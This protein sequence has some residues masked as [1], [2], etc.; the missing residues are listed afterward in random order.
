LD[1]TLLYSTACKWAQKQFELRYSHRKQ[2]NSNSNN[3]NGDDNEN[4]NVN[5]EKKV[6]DDDD[7][8]DDDQTVSADDDANE[9][10]M[11][12][13][14]AGSGSGSGSD[15]NS[16][17]INS[18]QELMQFLVPLIDFESFSYEM[19]F[20]INKADQVLSAEKFV[21]L[22]ERKIT[23]D[24]KKVVDDNDV[25]QKDEENEDMNSDNNNNNRNDV[26]SLSA[27]EISNLKIGS[28]VD[29]RDITNGKYHKC[30]IQTID[31]NGARILLNMFGCAK[32]FDHWLSLETEAHLLAK[33]CS[34]SESNIEHRILKHVKLEDVIL[35]HLP[36]Y[37]Q[38]SRFGWILA[39]VMQIENAQIKCSYMIEIENGNENKNQNKKEQFQWW[40]HADNQQECR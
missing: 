29:K 35:L 36:S 2:N 9:G 17:S 4:V 23:K 3:D 8:D 32:K 19:L 22:L 16:E 20:A 34:M 11:I 6:S 38:H 37:H 10:M 15:A 7:N 30:R 25:E 27:N 33:A 28:L 21:L 13:T 18:W 1:E 24:K 31:E 40:T 14:V 39:S 5:N 26:F 12:D